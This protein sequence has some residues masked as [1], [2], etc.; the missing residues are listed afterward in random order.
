[1]NSS[2][3][4]NINI[5]IQLRINSSYLFSGSKIREVQFHQKFNFKLLY[6]ILI[7]QLLIPIQLNQ[8]ES[9]CVVSIF[10]SIFF[11]FVLPFP[12]L[13]LF[14]MQR[15]YSKTVIHLNNTGYTIAGSQSSTRRTEQHFY[16]Q[17]VCVP[18]RFAIMV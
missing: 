14:V 12:L 16:G 7:L 17:R 1:M 4:I 6:F 15:F 5:T 10:C 3:F 11:Q 2:S 8:N 18:S 13:S 9:C